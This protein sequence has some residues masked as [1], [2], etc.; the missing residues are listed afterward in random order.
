MLI[1]AIVA[2]VTVLTLAPAPLPPAARP[3]APWGWPLPGPGAA[4]V[5]GFDP[6]V[7]PWE[8]GHRGVDLLGALD[9]PVLAAGA[10]VVTY[11]GPVAGVGVVTIAHGE[12][13]TTYQPV[14]A[15]VAIGDRV[16]V[17][18]QIG[19]LVRTG[20]H[21]APAACLHWGLLRGDTYLDPLA[22]VGRAGRPRLLPL[23]DRAV[24]DSG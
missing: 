6:P 21:C 5:R 23:G 15:T 24:A 14:R 17:G 11:A 4:V 20:S 18:D 13:R 22:M 12:L 3:D 2:V 10:G 8:A 19:T 7:L 9:A 1:R 16:T